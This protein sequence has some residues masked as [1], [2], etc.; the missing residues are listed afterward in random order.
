MVHALVRYS[1]FEKLHATLNKPPLS[2]FLEGTCSSSHK[3]FRLSMT[4][5]RLP[6]KKSVS[7]LLHKVTSWFDERDVPLLEERKTGLEMYLR[8]CVILS[9]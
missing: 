7:F 6:E 4:G 1:R 9:V 5:M 2:R 8:V 3:A